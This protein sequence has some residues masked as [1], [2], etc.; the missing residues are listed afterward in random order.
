MS[1]TTNN[2]TTASVKFTRNASRLALTHILDNVIIRPNI[3]DAFTKAG[4]DDTVGLLSL[5][6]KTINGLVYSHT[7][8]K[9]V[10]TTQKLLGGDVGPILNHLFTMYTTEIV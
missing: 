4:I 7:G 5:D 1:T 10:T 2:T 9:G 8:S 3:N 6:D